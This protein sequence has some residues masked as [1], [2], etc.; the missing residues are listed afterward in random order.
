M[1]Q[2]EVVG[3]AGN[4]AELKFIKGSKGEFAV[5][6]FSLA[7]S[8]REYKNGEWVQGETIWWKVSATGD[9]AEWLGDTPLKGI[10]LLV[11]G[12]LKQFEYTG[13]DGNVK[14]GFE[15]RA[16]MIAQV[17]TLKRKYEAGLYDNKKTTQTQG[18]DGWPF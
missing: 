7:E 18:D 13:R 2:I 12:D 3:N 4:D 11:K 5:A 9:L 1:A 14:Q 6:N 10:K 17:G 16:K 15:I 8:P